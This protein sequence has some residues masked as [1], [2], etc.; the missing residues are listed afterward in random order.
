MKEKINVTIEERVV[1]EVDKWAARYDL[2]RSQ[3]IENCLSVSL[4]EIKTL[5]A[6]GLLDLAQ[7]VGE[8]Q[9]RLRMSLKRE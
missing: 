9:E 1:R 2:N 3:M 5:K 6:I 7:V 8:V 4:A